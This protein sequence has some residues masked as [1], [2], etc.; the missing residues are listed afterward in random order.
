MIVAATVV[1][2]A[3]TIVG[4]ILT[5]RLSAAEHDGDYELM[6]KVFAS[7]MKDTEEEA[8]TRAELVTN[9]PAVRAAFIARDRP[10][11]LGECRQMFQVQ[12]ERYG[13]DQAQ[14]HTPPGISFLRLHDPSKFGDEQTSYDAMLADAHRT[15]SIRKGTVITRTGPAVFGIVPIIENG[16]L[17]GSFEIGLNFAPQLDGIKERYGLDAAVFFDEGL[18]REVATDLPGDVVSPKNRVGRFIRFHATHPELM[19]TLVTDK[20][21]DVTDPKTY[22][23][24]ARGIQLI[25]IYS[26]DKKRLG[27]VALTTDFGD[28]ERLARRVRIW[29]VLAA[30]FG[31]LAMCGAIFV[32]IRGVLISPL[33]DLNTRI[34]ALVRGEPCAPADPL[35]TYCEELQTLAANYEKLRER[36]QKS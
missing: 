31:I 1:V 6:R 26:S 25:P 12:Q 10:K 15:K 11:I 34:T 14:F 20:D 23:R 16:E 33:D 7:F 18:L 2:V 29:H 24:G 17:V 9:I 19:A 36:E 32:V 4:Q 22:E 35:E 21:V 13:V 5:S 8:L 27:V 3:I 28:D 30:L